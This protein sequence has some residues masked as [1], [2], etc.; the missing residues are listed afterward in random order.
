MTHAQNP[1][2]GIAL[3]ILAILLFTAMDAAAKGLIQRYPAPQVVWARFAGQ[4]LIVALVLNRRVPVLVRTRHPVLHLWR[5]LF[6][7]GATAFFFLSLTHIGLAEATALTD[8]N[9]VLITLGAALFLGEK[10][11]PRRIAGVVAALVG[12]MIIIRPG[13]GVFTPWALLPLGAALSYTGNA[14]LTRRLGPSESPWT[15]MIWAAGFGTLVAA[16]ALPFVW[17]PVAPA[18]LAIFALIGMLGTAAQLCLIRSF[19]IAEAGVV[20][21]FAYL[22]IVFATFWGGLF[23]GELPD[24]WTVIGALVIVGA[25]LYVWHRETNA[26][27]QERAA[28]DRR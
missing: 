7:M 16:L 10:L 4:F 18:D 12:A 27:R 9:P 24:Q 1:A 22:G 17:T 14:I 5:C 6:Q 23:Y 19:S 15:S 26:A 3:M 20:A 2:R 13:A 28:Q 11:G 8:L 25:G 21:P